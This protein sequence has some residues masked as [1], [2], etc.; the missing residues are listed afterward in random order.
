M[1]KSGFFLAC[2]V[3]LAAAG[4]LAAF[5]RDMSFE[6]KCEEADEVVVF[7][8][9]EIVEL[10]TGLAVE[11]HRALA[12]CRVVDVVAG[13][14]KPDERRLVPTQA[15]WDPAHPELEV[16]QSYLGFL[17][18]QRGLSVPVHYRAVARMNDGMIRYRGEDWGDEIALEDLRKR[19]HSVL[20][21]PPLG[22]MPF[23]PESG[24]PYR[25]YHPGTA[26]A[27]E[28]GLPLVVFLHG[29]GSRGDDNKAQLRQAVLQFAPHAGPRQSGH[30]GSLPAAVVLAP[31]CP[32]GQWWT[33]EVLKT[34][35][36]LAREW[37]ARPEIDCRRV[38]FAGLSM[39]GFGTWESLALAPDLI[40]AAVP[41]CGG[42]DPETVERFRHI[43]VRVYHGDADRVIPT[44]RS[45]EMV[46]ALKA[47]GGT[48]E[49]IELPG[50]EHD[51]W[52]PALV[53]GSAA[54][55]LLRQRRAAVAA[56]STD[57]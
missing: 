19:V 29:S 26:S 42:G 25:V 41:I 27:P 37:A 40:A 44:E 33:G 17:Q 20:A 54:H 51:A 47:A 52:T 30:P 32:A 57:D 2:A 21:E 9:E 15:L 34:A 36:A 35:I 3:F 28:T 7:E 18:N 10:P 50:I 1:P 38:Y 23:R 12:W 46:E 53:E 4:D 24:L 39:G 14:R 22:W 31:Q 45:R 11:A 49:Y 55:W 6:Q 16:G 8:V 48:V 13:R 43:P 5:A 56:D